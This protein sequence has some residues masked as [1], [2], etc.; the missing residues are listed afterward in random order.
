MFI[1]EQAFRSIYDL[2]PGAASEHWALERHV[3]SPRSCRFTHWTYEPL[4][5]RD[6]RGNIIKGSRRRNPFITTN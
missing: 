6:E 3:W 1:D 5:R 4:C 2:K